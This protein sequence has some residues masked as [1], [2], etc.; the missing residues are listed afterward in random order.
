MQL[1]ICIT[2]AFG[3][4]AHSR[5]DVDTFKH[6][7]LQL[8][9]ALKP[10]DG[11][12]QLGKPSQQLPSAGN[13]HLVF[14]RG[15]PFQLTLLQIGQPLE[16]GSS[17][18][19]ESTGQYLDSGNNLHFSYI[20]AAAKYCTDCFFSKGHEP[21]APGKNIHVR[22]NYQAVSLFKKCALKPGHI[23]SNCVLVGCL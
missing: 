8:G 23:L 16:V 11:F 10:S 9:N 15:P 4:A 19:K 14:S 21:R 1:V 22:T 5:L 13:E 3:T 6:G 17:C 7:F 12:L 2:Q 20:G 18:T